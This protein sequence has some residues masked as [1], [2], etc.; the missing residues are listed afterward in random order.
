MKCPRSIWMRYFSC[1]GICIFLCNAPKSNKFIF[2]SFPVL[3]WITW[4][5]LETLHFFYVR[6]LWNVPFFPSD[7]ENGVSQIFRTIESGE[8][9]GKSKWL[10]F[11]TKGGAE[12]EIRRFRSISKKNAHTITW[13]NPPSNAFWGISWYLPYSK[14]LE[15]DIRNESLLKWTKVQR[16]WPDKW[17]ML[18]LEIKRRI[19]DSRTVGHQIQTISR[20]TL[21]SQKWRLRL[22][23]INAL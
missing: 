19:Q 14:N 6:K 13:Q 12:N 1:D 10:V 7:S 16:S 15:I 23:I 21:R 20:C 4:F 17:S 22:E 11:E 2:G 5:F 18:L 8:F 9:Q 3:K